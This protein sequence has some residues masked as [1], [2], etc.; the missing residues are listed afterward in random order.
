VGAHANEEGEKGHDAKPSSHLGQV[1]GTG[2]LDAEEAIL[3][4][5]AIADAFR[6]IAAFEGCIDI[7]PVSI[8]V[9]YP[10]HLTLATLHKAIVDN[11]PGVE[12]L[13]SWID[14]PEN[15][16]FK[17]WIRCEK[18]L[19]HQSVRWMAMIFLNRAVVIIDTKWREE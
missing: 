16:A 5:T 2:P 7:L 13:S 3:L 1:I 12:K 15:K 14:E 6:E 9:R 8:W 11:E 19:S 10:E 18:R 4:L 17:G